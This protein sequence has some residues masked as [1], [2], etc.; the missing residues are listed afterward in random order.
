MIDGEEPLL[1]HDVSKASQALAREMQSLERQG[2]LEDSEL[3]ETLGHLLR[4]H[5]VIEMATEALSSA[6]SSAWPEH[7]EEEEDGADGLLELLV[8]CCS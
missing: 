4:G 1:Q 7:E 6:S 8:S 5:G 3:R 2:V